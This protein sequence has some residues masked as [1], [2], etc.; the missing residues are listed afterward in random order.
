MASRNEAVNREVA[1]VF[2]KMRGKHSMLTEAQAW[3]FWH[4][5]MIDRYVVSIPTWL[6]AHASGMKQGMTDKQA[7]DYADKAVRMSQGAGGAKDLS[8]I[9][10]DQH[11]AMRFFTLFYTPFNVMFNA[12]WQ[13]VRGL[14]KSQMAPMIGVTFW[15]MMTSMLADALLSGDAPDWDDEEAVLGWFGRNVF[16]GMF[17][18]VPLIRDIA[19]AT[20]R[21]AIGEYA[22]A[23]ATPVT[24]VY[25]AIDKVYKM[26]DKYVSEGESPKRPIKQIADLTA[27]LTGT[28]VSQAGTTGQFLW[29]YQAGEA[30]PQSISDWYF[31]VTRGKVPES[32]TE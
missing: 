1:E 32:E 21:K 14:K 2:S 5:G 3:A 26:G 23:G 13:G 18:G 9:Q 19:G 28:P 20:E 12:Q 15:W 27:L 10:G 6:G 11:P 30:D 31:G 25:D 8:R 29:D 16:F 17:A 24:R 4:I 7:S 22:D